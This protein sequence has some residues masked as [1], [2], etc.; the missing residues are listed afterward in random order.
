MVLA[1]LAAWRSE[2]GNL[3]L[4]MMM[5][6]VHNCSDNGRLFDCS[7]YTRNNTESSFMHR[8]TSETMTTFDKKRGEDE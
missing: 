7:I 5:I 3:L 1:F 4:M 8:P 2:T 6:D